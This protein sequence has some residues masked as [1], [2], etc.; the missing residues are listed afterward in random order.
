MCVILFLD[1]LYRPKVPQY[2]YNIVLDRIVPLIAIISPSIIIVI[3]N[4]ANTSWIAKLG[5][6]ILIYILF[7][8]P[9]LRY[10]SSHRN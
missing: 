1:M 4:P 10:W 2:P 6:I 9:L 7:L 5:Y 3:L 8:I